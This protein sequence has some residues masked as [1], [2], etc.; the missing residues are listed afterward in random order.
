MMQYRRASVLAAMCAIALIAIGCSDSSTS[1]TT[2][3][4]LSVTGTA[5]AIGASMQFKATATMADGSTQDVTSQ[6][7]WSSSNTTVAT[8]SSAGVVTGVAAGSVTVSAI[9]QSISGA[10][11]ISVAAP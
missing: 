2:A 8:V 9:Y 7:A 10:D 5:P 1:A 6:S 3:T 11:A 4:S